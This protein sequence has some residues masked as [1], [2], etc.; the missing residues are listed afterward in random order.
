MTG[1]PLACAAWTMEAAIPFKSLRYRPGREQTWGFNARRRIRWKNE[2]SYR[3]A[4]PPGTGTPGTTRPWT[5]GTLV[6]RTEEGDPRASVFYISYVRGGVREAA[7]RPVTSDDDRLPEEARD[8]RLLVRERIG[9]ATRRPVVWVERCW[10]GQAA[11]PT[12]RHPAG[13]HARVHHQRPTSPW[14]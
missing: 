8:L 3:A 11:R 10:P 2:I 1:T 7:D 5:A 14:R 9:V 13:A 12:L 4:V 6:L